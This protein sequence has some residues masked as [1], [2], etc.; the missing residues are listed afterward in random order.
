LCL[1]LCVTNW[2]IVTLTNFVVQKSVE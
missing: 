1:V 2:L